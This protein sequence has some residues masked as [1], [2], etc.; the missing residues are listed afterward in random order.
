MKNI[1]K[2]VVF[3]CIANAV[4]AQ[5]I[6]LTSQYMF[7]DYLLN[8]AIAGSKDYTQFSLS[9]RAQW[10]GLDGAPQTQFFSAQTKIGD[11][12]GL[13]GFVYN[14]ETGPIRETGFQL[15][16]AYHL[17]VSDNS[18]LSFSLGGMFASHYISKARLR[19]EEGGDEA[20]NNLKIN[21]SVGDINFGILYYTEKYKVGIS[22][23]QI[24]QSKLYSGIEPDENQSN[25]ARHYNLYGEYKFDINDDIA[26][27]PST[28]VKYVQGAPIQADINVR[29]IYKQN[30]WIGV[31]YRYNNAVSAMLGLSYRNLSFGYAYDYTLTD[32]NSYSTGGHE[33]FLSLKVFK[34]IEESSKKFD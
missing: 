16:Y 13:G 23:P 2:V 8:P 10:T 7:N 11:K 22:S 9:A 29:G 30:Y 32:M 28:L 6:P 19:P 20:L 5:Q 34:K 27:V 14:D 24:L 15:S 31:S 25:L 17:T 26:V 3:V 18:K 1:L 21:S 4:S 33:I 12:M